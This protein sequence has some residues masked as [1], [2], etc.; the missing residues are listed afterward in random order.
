MKNFSF[1]ALLVMMLA[2]SSCK[3]I[4]KGITPTPHQQYK[5]S[6]E[7]AGL[8][9]AAIYKN[10]VK[11]SDLALKKTVKIN[12]LPYNETGYF[13]PSA[14]SAY[15]FEMQGLKGQQ[16]RINLKTNKRDSLSLFLDFWKKTNDGLLEEIAYT[17]T[18][19]TLI[20]IMVKENATYI[21]R[22]QP[23]LAKGGK[24]VLSM[25]KSPQYAFP[26]KGFGNKAI[27]SFWGVDR[28][29][30]ARQHQGIDI[31]APRGTPV[32]AVSDG[33]ITAL[34]ETNLGGLVVWQNIVNNNH[35]A[36]YA[37]LSKQLVADGDMVKRGD[38][39]GLVGNTG[40]AKTTSPH[41]HFGIYEIGGAIDPLLFVQEQDTFVNNKSAYAVTDASLK[42]I[43]LKADA[44]NVIPVKITASSNKNIRLQL[45]DGNYKTVSAND[46]SFNTA[47]LKL[48]ILKDHEVYTSP[49]ENNLAIGMV[50]ATDEYSVLGKLNKYYFIRKGSLKGWILVN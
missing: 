34:Q 22:L 6:L 37:H 24:Y 49:G 44:K 23:E 35:S 14:I 28:D 15:A 40:N 38:T 42:M 30:G 33:R 18:T 9:Q 41:L 48:S 1:F 19:D 3:T 4:I 26:V 5:K 16:L 27:Q 17:Q 11:A 10:W 43:R 50:K 31:F 25:V 7:N 32:L 20:N 46:F 2:C 39:I 8:Q 12:E 45:P 47:K 21:L 13:D 36:Y 29:G